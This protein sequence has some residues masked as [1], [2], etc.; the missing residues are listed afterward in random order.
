MIGIDV[1]FGFTKI[2]GGADE[3]KQI[4]FPSVFAPYRD[5]LGMGE[6]L[7]GLNNLIIETSGEKYL[8]GDLAK[9]EGGMATFNKDNFLRHRLCMLTGISLLTEDGY[10]GPVVMGLPISDLK[11]KN[12]LILQL[13]DNY[14][15]KVCNK[16]YDISIDDIWVVPQG[17]AAYFDLVYHS[18]GNIIRNNKIA[19]KKIGIID[20]GEKTLDFVC[21]NR[22]QFVKEES[23]SLD[24]GMNRA[25]LRLHNII[26][27][28]LDINP[29]PHQVS[30]YL[31]RIPDA[32]SKEFKRLS[33]DIA[34]QISRWWNYKDFDCIY[35]AG[36]GGA[37]LYEYMKFHIQCELIPES[38]ISNARGY[39]KCGM[40]RS[41]TGSIGK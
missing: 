36:G 40:A 9:L 24:L 19:D 35:L 23:G 28:D 18:D 21:M 8:I 38:Q 26:Q 1:G 4:L 14:T 41:L 29:M 3:T 34:N 7:K 22:S 15:I 5:R 6:N 2:Y 37:A 13:K 30:G 16:Q 10:A 27:I 31:S 20:I 33:E 32:T 17:A 25:Y 39:Y 11:K 12:E